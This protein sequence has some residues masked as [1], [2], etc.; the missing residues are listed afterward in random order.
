MSSKDPAGARSAFGGRDRARSVTEIQ[1]KDLGDEFQAW[2]QS[3]LMADR[4]P[5]C[6]RG[7]FT[8]PGSPSTTTV[9][10]CHH[11]CRLMAYAIHVVAPRVGKRSCLFAELLVAQ[12]NSRV[13][14]SLLGAATRMLSPQASFE[15]LERPRNVW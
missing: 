10:C 2:W 1:A 8:I 3:C 12:D 9:L 6:L 5:P 7:Q 15:L 11:S 14:T 4:R 13:T